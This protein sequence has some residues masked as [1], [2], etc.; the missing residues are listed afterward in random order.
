MAERDEFG[1][2]LIG[3][4]IGGLTGAVSA[5]LMAPQSGVET[6]TIIREK[7][8]ELRDRASETVEDAYAQAEQAAVEA[9]T[10]ADELAK[11]ARERA[12][13]LQRRGQVVLEEQRAKIGGAIQQAA[14][15]TD[16]TGSNT[17]QGEN[18]P[19][20]SPEI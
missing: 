3:F 8:I 16:Q 13:E 18:P 14:K 19:S 10:R 2:F 11:I 1:A 17:S 4:I 20:T 6:R 7:A 15:K 9:R 5:L 12:E